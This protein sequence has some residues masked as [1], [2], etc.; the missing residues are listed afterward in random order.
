MALVSVV[1]AETSEGWPGVRMKP[2]IE[3]RLKQIAIDAYSSR[4]NPAS[5]K[6]AP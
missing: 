5:R 6:P 1:L 4:E 2:Y 3:E